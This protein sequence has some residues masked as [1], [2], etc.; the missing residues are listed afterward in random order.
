VFHEKIDFKNIIEYFWNTVDLKKIE[1]SDSLN[2]QFSIINSQFRLVRFR[3]VTKNSVERRFGI[4]V[5]GGS[6]R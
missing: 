5:F 4:K 2:I 3:Q 1:H 6:T